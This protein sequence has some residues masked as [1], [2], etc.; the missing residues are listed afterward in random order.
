MEAQVYPDLTVRYDGTKYSVPY[1][2][3][4]R[5]VTLKATPFHI[6]VYYLGEQ[7]WEPHLRTGLPLPGYCGCT[8]RSDAGPGTGGKGGYESL[9]PMDE[10]K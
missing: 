2:L 1:A 6:Q 5:K 7:I 8:C 4:G 9:W 3:A 10:R